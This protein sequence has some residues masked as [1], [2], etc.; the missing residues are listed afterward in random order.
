MTNKDDFQCIQLTNPHCRSEDKTIYDKTCRTTVIFNCE[1]AYSG[2]QISYESADEGS[3]GYRGHSGG[4]SGGSSGGS[5]GYGGGKCQ[6]SCTRT[7]Q[8]K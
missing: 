5:G 3:A 7:P 4:Y 1:Q 6:T 8:T 2:G